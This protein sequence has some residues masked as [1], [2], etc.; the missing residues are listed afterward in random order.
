VPVTQV[1]PGL[2]TAISGQEWASFILTRLQHASVVL[3]S[4][5]RRLTTSSPV[6]HVPRF[7]GDG[8]AGWYLELEEIAEGAPPGDDIEMIMRKCAT[9]A[10]IS[11]EVVSDASRAAINQLGET[12]MSAVGLTVDRAIFVG[13]GPPRQPVGIVGQITQIIEGDVV[14]LDNVID[15]AG[16]IADVGGEPNALYLAPADW[17]AWQKV[18]DGVDRPLLNPDVTQAAA[19]Q[20]AGLSVYRTP[21]LSSGTAVVAQADQIIVAVRDD[22]AIEMSSDALFTSDGHVVRITN[23][24][25]VAIND[26]RGLSKIVP[27]AARAAGEKAESTRKR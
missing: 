22:P 27:T 15:A 18:R 9:L 16:L 21:A 13:A 11:S 7:T 19:P 8:S 3:R 6:L 26:S 10:K 1:P 2:G 12:M 24:L 17:T 5:A 4:G 14:D 23:R 25:D 20:L